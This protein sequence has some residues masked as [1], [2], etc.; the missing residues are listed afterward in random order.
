MNNILTKWELTKLPI[1]L[2]NGI[3]W[4]YVHVFVF[5]MLMIFNIGTKLHVLETWHRWYWIYYI[6]LEFEEVLIEK[7]GDMKII[8][9][10]YGLLS[11]NLF[12][13]QTHYIFALKFKYLLYI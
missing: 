6:Y 8:V 12:S 10:N 9:V 4:I 5:E 11:F 1:F 2:K 7:R 3:S 13:K